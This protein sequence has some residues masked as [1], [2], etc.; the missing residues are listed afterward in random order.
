MSNILDSVATFTALIESPVGPIELLSDG[1]SLVGLYFARHKNRQPARSQ[2]DHSCP[3]LT[4]TAYQLEEYFAGTRRVFDLPLTASG[5]AFQQKVWESLSTI[6]FGE[7]I[8]YA[9]QARRI[10]NPRASR[11]VGTAN[12]RNPISII[13]PCHRVIGKS[14]Q[15]TGYGGGLSIKEWLLDHENQDTPRRTPP[16]RSN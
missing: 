12:G 11:A 9:E 13:I 2:I 8:S 14:G 1:R 16:P 5:T 10:G 3:V 15:L 6:P 4:A 7:C